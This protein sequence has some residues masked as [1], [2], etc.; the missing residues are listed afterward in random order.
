VQDALLGTNRAAA[1]GQEVEINLGAKP[2]ATAMTSAFPC[3]QHVGLLV[4]SVP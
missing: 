1:G 3:F 4:F 2:H